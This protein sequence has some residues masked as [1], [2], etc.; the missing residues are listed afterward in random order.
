MNG[1]TQTDTRP[2]RPKP[3]AVV[4]ENIPAELKELNQW[5]TWKYEFRDKWTK[6]PFQVNGRDYAKS[7][8][9]S[10]WGAFHDA[11]KT[12]ESRRVD[13]IGVALAI[14]IGMVGVDL[15][16]C[17]NPQTKS[18]EPWATK[19]IERFNSYTEASPSGT[20]VRIFLKGK[21]PAGGHKK[22]NIEIYSTGRYLTVTGRVLRNASSRAIEPRQLEI[23]AFL[24]EHF[25][26][27]P[28]SKPNPGNG[29]GNGAWHP[30]DD[31]LLDRAIAAKNGDK[32][33]RLFDGDTSEHGGD[34]SAADLALCSHLAFWTQD[35]A[36]IDR[37]FR[38]S[39]LMREKWN[40]KH[41]TTTYG[42]RTVDKALAGRTE[43]YSGSSNGDVHPEQVTLKPLPDNELPVTCSGEEEKDEATT[44]AFPEAAWTGLFARWRDT[45]ASCTEASLETLWGAFLLAVGMVIGRNAWRESPRPLYPNFYLLLMGETGDSR[46]STVMWLACE[47]LRRVGED[48][49]ELDGVVSAEG[50]YEA[51]ADRDGTKGLIY[52]DE[53]RALL[54]VAKRRGTQ[55][56]LPRLNSLYY[57]PDRASIDRVKDSTIITRPF[58]SLVTATPKAYIEDILSDL[59]I[60]GG[61]LNRFLI[62]SGNEQPPKPIVKS[63]SPAAWEAIASGV[64]ELKDRTVG[65]LEM[66]AEAT[67]LWTNFYTG[68][69]TERREWHPKQANLS[70]RT[71]EHVLKIGVV[72][73]VLAGENQISVKSLAIA[74]AVGG[75]LQFNTLRLFADSGLD[76]L[77]KAER[78]ILDLLKRANN[79]RMWRRDL[80]QAVSK[81][82]FNGEVFNRAIKALESNDYIRC[83]PIISP[84][85]RERPIV[86]YIREQV[87]GKSA[88]DKDSSVTCSREEQQEEQQSERI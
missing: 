75:W 63:P 17:Y 19:I 16:H 84:A 3:L 38:R 80:Q 77:G 59:E 6:P 34:D 87:T 70:A 53:F 73:S 82:G 42:E 55:D 88:P 85:G 22:G 86:E 35:P 46:K 69:K 11:L 81:R 8:D 31:E 29:N 83:R 37:I 15:D 13:G 76:Y 32:V 45:V 7:S 18:F 72:Y 43:H 79:G 66:T 54:S 40:E 28:K 71:F 56:I 61:F 78:I 4:A 60:T 49:K 58:L 62:I 65:H 47:L 41:G 52:A 23:D 67:E 9:P 36:Q 30:S 2:P 24:L 27:E 25:S 20:G 14:D 74:I 10:T 48:F 33:R 50:V 64:R 12:Y 44:I 1:A 57:C 26:P 5:V 39:G 68:W 21:L 51:L